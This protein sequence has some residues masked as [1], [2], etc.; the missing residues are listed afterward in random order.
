[1]TIRRHGRVADLTWLLDHRHDLGRH[2]LGAGSEGG[3]AIRQLWYPA[4]EAAWSTL[5]LHYSTF[6]VEHADLSKEFRSCPSRRSVHMPGRS[7]LAPAPCSPS[8]TSASSRSWTAAISS[9]WRLTRR[10][11]C[12]ARHTPSPSHCC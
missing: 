8:S 10:F 6:R 11:S 9:R 12:S 3:V 4:R 7:P 2:R 1:M 5:A